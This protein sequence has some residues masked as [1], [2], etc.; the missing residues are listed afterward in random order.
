MRKYDLQ[1][2]RPHAKLDCITMN[3]ILEEVEKQTWSGSGPEFWFNLI[4]LSWSCGYLAG[5]RAKEKLPELRKAPVDPYGH[6][7]RKSIEAM[8]SAEAALVLQLPDDPDKEAV[9]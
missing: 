9:Q 6:M 5:N 4:V 7:V 3:K 1:D 8:D 2:T